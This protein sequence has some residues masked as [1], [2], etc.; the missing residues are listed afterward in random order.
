MS[1]A[2]ATRR[3]KTFQL[4]H[5]W[6]IRIKSQGFYARKYGTYFGMPKGTSQAYV[7]SN[8]ENIKVIV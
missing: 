3:N 7:M 5:G 1:A 4:V 8:S 6:I 2:A